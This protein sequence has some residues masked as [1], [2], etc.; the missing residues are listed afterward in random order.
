[1]DKV[2]PLS[3]LHGRGTAD[4]GAAI[5]RRF[6]TR[7]L[8]RHPTDA[9]D[10]RGDREWRS[11]AAPTR[12]NR[13]FSTDLTGIRTLARRRPPRHYPRPRRQRVRNRR[14]RR[15]MLVDTAGVRRRSKVS[16]E[17]E[18]ASVMRA[19]RSI[20]R[21]EIVVLMCDADAGLA[22][23]DQRLLGLAVDRRRAIV[24]G[25]EQGRSWW[26]RRDRKK[27]HGAHPAFALHFAPW[28]PVVP[29]SAKTGEGVGKTDSRRSR[30][31]AVGV[32]ASHLHVG[33]QPLLRIRCLSVGRHRPSRAKAPRLYYVTQAQSA[34]PAFVAMTS[35]PDAIAPCLSPIR[36]QPNP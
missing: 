29:M 19:I 26:R 22:E 35:A 17:V 34:P 32:L 33:A 8:V 18:S 16:E 25:L 3:S 30:K 4:L 20:G 31:A 9:D 7:R 10:R 2:I 14:S 24:V 1:M 21:A 11:S 27:S 15:F 23:Q 12:E 13:R 5:T 36:R 28:A 6:A